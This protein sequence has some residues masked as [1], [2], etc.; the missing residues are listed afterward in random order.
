MPSSVSDKLVQ[1][2]C[3]QHTMAGIEVYTF[4]KTGI[5]S[6]VDIIAYGCLSEVFADNGDAYEVTNK[7]RERIKTKYGLT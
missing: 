6:L 5:D 7:I 1:D 4:T 3:K 2:L